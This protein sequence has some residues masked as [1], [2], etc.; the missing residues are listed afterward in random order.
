MS[1]GALTVEVWVSS[2]EKRPRLLSREGR[3]GCSEF[4]GLHLFEIS[5]DERQRPSHRPRCDYQAD[6]RH[7]QQTQQTE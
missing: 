4:H 3:E 2:N 1:S 7:E 6:R 5:F